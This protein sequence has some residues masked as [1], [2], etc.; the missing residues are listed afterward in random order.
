MFRTNIS[1]QVSKI[2]IIDKYRIE[3]IHKQ[4]GN[5]I[6]HVLFHSLLLA[7][8]IGTNFYGQNI[9]QVKNEWKNKV[10]NW[11][12]IETN[13]DHN[14]LAVVDLYSMVISAEKTLSQPY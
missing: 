3:L 7:N 9:G 2:I 5:I 14:I 13:L 4:P 12:Y 8:N 6:D 11:T 1:N 10:I